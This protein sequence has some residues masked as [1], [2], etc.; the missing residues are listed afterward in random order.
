MKHINSASAKKVRWILEKRVAQAANE[1]NKKRPCFYHWKAK[2]YTRW[3]PCK[4]LICN[5]RFGMLT[6]LHAESHG[7]A[8]ADAMIASGNVTFL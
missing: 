1:M 3:N 2:H 8:S 6:N 5:S 4:C 7:F